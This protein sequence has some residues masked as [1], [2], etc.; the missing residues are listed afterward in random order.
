M[1]T[2]V[3]KFWGSDPQNC[4]PS[5][6]EKRGKRVNIS[7]CGLLWEVVHDHFSQGRKIRMEQNMPLLFRQFADLDAP[8][9]QFCKELQRDPGLGVYKRQ[10]TICKMNSE[11]HNCGVSH[12]LPCKNRTE[13]A[14]TLRTLFSMSESVA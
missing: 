4:L 13:L 8:R 11:G 9:F 12:R 7:Q 3:Q 2:I 10:V 6:V 1:L 5:G 14:A